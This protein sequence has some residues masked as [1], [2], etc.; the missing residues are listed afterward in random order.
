MSRPIPDKLIR[1]I[2]R[3]DGAIAMTPTRWEI[4]KLLASGKSNHEIAEIRGVS[5]DTIRKE[6]RKI[7]LRLEVP[8]RTALVAKCFREGII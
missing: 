8:N 3:I 2:G 7:Y 4:L 1:N 6:V 5:Y